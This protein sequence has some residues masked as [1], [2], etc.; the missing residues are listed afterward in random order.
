MAQALR[1]K[2]TATQPEVQ[3]LMLNIVPQFMP[4]TD[5]TLDTSRKR[6]P[7]FV[8][9][10]VDIAT[11]EPVLAEERMNCMYSQINRVLVPSGQLIH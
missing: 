2:V 9:V 7:L 6:T 1:R 4:I 3:G 5:D 11:S 10:K 8:D